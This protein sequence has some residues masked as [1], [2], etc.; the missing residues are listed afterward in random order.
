MKPIDDDEKMSFHM[1]LVGDLEL[2]PQS[3]HVGDQE[4]STDYFV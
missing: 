2:I 4:A 3:M 1:W